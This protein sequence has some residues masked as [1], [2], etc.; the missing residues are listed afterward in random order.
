MPPGCPT[1][2]RPAIRLHRDIDRL[3]NRDEAF[4]AFLAD[5]TDRVLQPWHR[6]EVRG[7]DR[8]PPGPGLY[9]GNHNG[10]LMIPDSFLF[11]TAVYRRRGLDDLP[12]MLG[13]EVALSAPVLNW[14]TTGFGAVRASHENARRL[15]AEGHKVL[16]Y[17]GGDIDAL[18]PWRH[19][20]RLVFGRRKG[21][22]R[23]ALRH[24]VPVIPVVAAG[25]H[26]GF[27]VIDDFRW[28]ARLI[29]ADRWLRLKVWPLIASVPWGLTFGVPPPVYLPWPSRIL[30]EVLPP[31]T[32]QR[33]GPDAAADPVH[34]LRCARQVETAMQDTLTRLAAEL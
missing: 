21:Y 13:H 18:R 2:G 3:D 16:V 27:L 8:I 9:V 14:I 10:G 6:A 15:F 31:I 25:A 26:S 24:G 34:V 23:L 28:F 20:N 33:T 4:L 17:P 1:P 30:V 12:Y 22:I 19:R 29:G 5:V 32:F 7:V 11:G